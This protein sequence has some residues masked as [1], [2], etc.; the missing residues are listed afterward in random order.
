VNARLVALT[1]PAGSGKST[2][3]RALAQHSRTYFNGHP[4][5]RHRVAGPLK[6]MLRTLGLTEEQVDGADKEK[7]CALLGGKTPRH[8]MQT[9][10]TEWGR[11]CI[12]PGLWLRATMLVVERDLIAGHTAVIDDLRFDN[13]AEAVHALGGMVVQL[14]RD[15]V[16]V[17]SE[18]AS[19]AGLAAHH[20]HYLISNNATPQA[21][22]RD[23][24]WLLNNRTA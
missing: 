21:A 8:A 6:A 7:P 2:V 23:I 4:V 24:A 13:E 10:G 16:Q 1:G 20:V 17:T 12:D 9:L 22:A 15:G 3:A 14:R 18:H 11:G 19:E 5:Y